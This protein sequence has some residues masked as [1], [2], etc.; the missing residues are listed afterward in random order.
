MKPQYLGVLLLLGALWGTSF[1]FIKIAVVE[2]P[3]E[4]LVALRLVVGALILLAALYGTGGRLPATRRA[5]RDFVFTGIFGLLLP[6]TLITWGEQSISSGMASILNAT[7]PLFTALVAY[8][9]LRSDHLTGWKLLGVVLGFAGVIVAVGVSDLSIGSASTQGQLAVLVAAACYGV[10]G[11]YARQ[12]Y[13][14]L[15]PLVPATGQLVCG[16]LLMLPIALFA[17]GVPNALP[18]AQALGAVVALGLFGTAIAY[19]LL[20]WL[21]ARIGSTRASMVT[22]LL[23]PFALVYGALFLKEIIPL[24]ALLGLAL[25]IVGILLS[26]NMIRLPGAKPAVA[27]RTPS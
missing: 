7:T 19:I 11:V 14:G 21:M 25:V 18:S 15:P 16:A 9:W 27:G 12:A 2:M 20:Y 17:N 8:I 22:Y 5:W 6:F 24:H 13:K 10:S 1:L 23:P 26:N 3:P 4:T